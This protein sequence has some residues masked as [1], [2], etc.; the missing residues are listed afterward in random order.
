MDAAILAEPPKDDKLKPVIADPASAAAD[1][2]RRNRALQINHM[3]CVKKSLATDVT[4]EVYRLLR[5]S[6][7]LGAKE[8]PASPFGLEENR[9]NLEIAIDYVFRQGLIP[10]RYEVDELFR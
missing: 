9:R 2:Q 8:D 5:E 1:W 7:N 3:V 6:K 10:R 4:Q